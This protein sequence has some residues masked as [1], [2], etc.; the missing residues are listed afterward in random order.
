MPHCRIYWACLSPIK[1][2]RQAFTGWAKKVIPLVQCN[3]MYEMY[4]FFGPPCTFQSKN[5]KSKIGPKNGGFWESSK[6]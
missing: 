6:F 5:S 3:V 4:H 2:D 1:Q